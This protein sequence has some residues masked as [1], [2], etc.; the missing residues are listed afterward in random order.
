MPYVTKI[1]NILR[2]SIYENA[3][4]GLP[5]RIVSALLK[6]GAQMLPELPIQINESRA[7]GNGRAIYVWHADVPRHRP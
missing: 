6:S 4:L 3:Y 2:D 7:A 1:I 5:P